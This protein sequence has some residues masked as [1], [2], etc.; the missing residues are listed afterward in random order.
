MLKIVPSGYESDDSSV[1]DIEMLSAAFLDA[2]QTFSKACAPPGNFQLSLLILLS[3]NSYSE[4]VRCNLLAGGCN[5]SRANFVGACMGAI[6]GI[7]GEKGIPVEW[8]VKTDVGARVLKLAMQ[9]FGG[10]ETCI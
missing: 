9:L 3:T 2:S 5:C 6:F 4:A 8:I 7:G 1:W 10:G